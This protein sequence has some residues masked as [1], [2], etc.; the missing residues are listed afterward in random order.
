[1][2]DAALQLGVIV[3]PVA[4]MGGA[5]GLKGTD[6][7]AILQEARARGA[8][9][10]APARAHEALAVI[11]AALGK[12]LDVLAAAGP[13]GETEAREAG[14]SVTVKGRAR[15]ETTAKD[16]IEAARAMAA[17]GVRLILFAG[18]DGTARDLYAAVGETVPVVGVPAGVKMHSAAYATT[19]RAAGELAARFLR[20]GLVR[21]S[22]EVMDIDEGAYRQG[23]VA[24]QLYGFLSVPFH[25]DL[26]QGVKSGRVNSDAAA[27][28]AIAVEVVDRLEPGR[29]YILGPGTTTRAI[30][31]HIGVEKTLLGVD[32]I[33]D[34]RIVAADA[35]EAALLK[36]IAEGEATVIVTPIG[37]QGHILGRGNQQ[38]S[39][40][41]LRRLG[42][43][44][45]LVVATPEKLA[46]LQGRPLL[47]DTGDADLDR[48]LAGYIRVITGYRT[49]AVCPV[50]A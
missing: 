29:L 6:S 37:G 41:V 38:I 42:R 10:R 20:D 47:V 12:K 40:A 32:V 16:T 15:G 18:G 49:E 17:A 33:R 25:R 19:P 39:P 22:V 14:L 46:S 31:R 43:S 3:N 1:M 21:R 11:A 5:V 9:P 28:E 44:R 7:A 27:V 30:A 45:L 23:I 36:A 34:G 13:M 48:E 26:L 50:S 8:T 2:A 35:G 24:P 4:G